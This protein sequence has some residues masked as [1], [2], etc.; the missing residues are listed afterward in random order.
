MSNRLKFLVQLLVASWVL[1]AASGVAQA[2]DDLRDPLAREL[3]AAGDAAMQSLRY[4]DALASYER[5]TEIEPNPI[6]LFNRARALQA[7]QR[8]P[9]ALDHFEAFQREASPQLLARAGELDALIARLRQQTSTLEV[10]CNVK[11]ATVLVRGKQIGR[12]P[13][14]APIRL[15]AG[16]ASIRV[17]ADGHYPY[18]RDVDLPGAG[19]RRLEI[20]LV[21]KK[22]EGRLTIRSPIAGAVVYV[23]GERLGTVPAEAALE[24]GRHRVRVEHPNYRRAE[25]TVEIGNGDTKQIDIE[26]EKN[27]G[28]LKKWWFW[29]GAGVVLAGGVGATIA[30]TTERKAGRGDIPPGTISAPLVSF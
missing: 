16:P 5:A 18:E 3:K 25:T 21:A 19:T 22:S 10:L 9:E 6:L 24:S 29:T 20:H 4:A 30:L 27:P 1:L 28:L 12:T 14:E 2:D 13:L 11:G 7:L 26:L 23:D 8:F 15:N 17:T